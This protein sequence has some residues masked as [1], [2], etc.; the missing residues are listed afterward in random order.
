MTRLRIFLVAFGLLLLGS[1]VLAQSLIVVNDLHQFSIASALAMYENE[2]GK[3]KKPLADVTFPYA[4]VRMNLKGNEHA[5]NLAKERITLY[6]GQQT[7]VTEKCTAYSDQILFLVPACRA[8]IYIDCGYGCELVQ[9]SNML[10]LKSNCVYDCTVHFLP[11]IEETPDVD[12][13]IVIEYQECINVEDSVVGWL[14]ISSD[15]VDLQGLSAELKAKDIKGKQGKIKIDLPA[16]QEALNAGTYDVVIKKRKYNAYKDTVIIVGDSITTISPIFE[17]KT[18]RI[19]TFVLAEAGVALNPEW[20]VGLMV[21]QMYNG[22]G[23]WLKGHSNWNIPR[24]DDNYNLYF[25]TNKETTSLEWIVNGGLVVDFLMNKEKK[26]RNDFLG[27]YCGVGYGSRKRYYW[28]DSFDSWVLYPA[29]LYQGISANIGLIGSWHGWTLMA[30]LNTIAFKYMEV[31]MGI[32][33]TF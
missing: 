25:A 29:N 27:G 21:G 16:Q 18:Y 33:Y 24:I 23:W 2:F 30:G 10:Q 12:T 14:S 28:N 32:G 8:M 17:R 1:P 20:G 31:E 4:V 15:S 5:V 9:L 13:V 19:N 3:Y 6:M 7:S 22:I 11:E 26:Y